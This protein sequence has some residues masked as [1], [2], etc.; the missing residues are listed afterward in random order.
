MTTYTNTAVEGLELTLTNLD[1]TLWP[2]EGYTKGELIQYYAETAPYILPYLK[3]RPLVT[4]RY[5]DGID[6]K[7]F[8]QKNAPPNLPG[9]INTYRWISRDDSGNNLILAEKTADLVWL[10]NL[11]C[12]E[13]HPWL[14]RVNSIMK[15][16]FVVFDLD[17]SPG[18]SFENVKEIALFLKKLFD[19]LEL[20]VYLKTTGSEGLHVFLPVVN[21]YTYEQVR[22]FARH[23]AEAVCRQLPH[24]AT[25]ERVVAK[26]K[27]KVYVDYLQNVI[28]KTIC[29]PYS[30]RPRPGAPVSAPIGWSELAEISS[31]SFN[32][33]NI[34][35]RL[36]QINEHFKPVLTD[37]QKLER[38][39]KYF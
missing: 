27:N 15:P 24:I 16:D 29:A 25:I 17:P 4:T 3:D 1:K 26:R 33:K 31:R 9:W 8:Y 34:L 21:Q 32:I 22:E 39:F 28:G 36:D 7:F 13:I 23:I 18:S 14:S 6:G 11:A 30:V 19:C 35:G 5:P 20:R 37:C 38:A 10:A 2:A 12:I